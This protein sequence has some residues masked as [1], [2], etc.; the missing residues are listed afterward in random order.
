MIPEK[1]PEDQT[2]IRYNHIGRQSKKTVA[3]AV[4]LSDITS[5]CALQSENYSGDKPNRLRD[6]SKFCSAYPSASSPA[7]KDSAM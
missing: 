2:K 3:D 6:P 4:F 7:A 1:S 5:F